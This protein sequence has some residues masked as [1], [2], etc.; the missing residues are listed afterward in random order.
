MPI[1]RFL[2]D[3]DEIPEPMN[4]DSA[5]QPETA[6]DAGRSLSMRQ[7]EPTFENTLN[8]QILIEVLPAKGS[9]GN[10]N[11]RSSESSR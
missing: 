3:V 2:A 4:L 7:L 9:A 5:T 6:Q 11:T 1:F 10:P 8:G